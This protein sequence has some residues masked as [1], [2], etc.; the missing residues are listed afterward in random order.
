MP[1]SA[2]TLIGHGFLARRDFL[3]H[4]GS[5]LGGIA[6]C[7]LLAEQGLTAEERRPIRPTISPTAPLAGR[8]AHFT[9]KAKRVLHIF[10]SG[11]CSQLD[12]WDYKPELVKRHGQPLPGGEN[13]VTFQ[14]ANG[15]LTKSPY[16][17]KPR[18]QSGKYVTDLLPNLAELADEMC[19]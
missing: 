16:T 4:L 8:P 6:L 3:G 11:A 12:T 18:G 19:F 15:A 9:A 1:D 7:S 17:F 2:P 10:C 14:G 13:L 5:G